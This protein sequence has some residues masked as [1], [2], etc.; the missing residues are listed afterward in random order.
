M[1]AGRECDR[2]IAAGV[3]AILLP[4]GATAAMSQVSALAPDGRCK[5]FASDGDG[6]GRG[7]GFS[8]LLLEPWHEAAGA[9]APLAVLAATAV[10]QDGRSSGLTAPHGPSQTALV[11]AAIE[12][13]GLQTVDYIA[14]HGTGTPLGGKQTLPVLLLLQRSCRCS[15]VLHPSMQDDTPVCI[16]PACRSDRGQCAA[17]CPGADEIAQC[18][19]AH[20]GSRQGKYSCLHSCK[21]HSSHGA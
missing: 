8:A 1:S 17:R 18:C 10:N 16:L 5:A 12:E 11:K 13:A 15:L 4:D 3:N 14:T 21:V 19:A 20:H 6:Y 7:E 2:A 9:Q